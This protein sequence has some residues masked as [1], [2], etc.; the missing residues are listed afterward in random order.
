MPIAPSVNFRTINNPADPT[1]NNLQ[2]INNRGVIDG[3]YG[4]GDPGHPNEGY[5]TTTHGRVFTP[6]EFPN[7]GQT[8]ANGL[9]DYGVVVGYFY[10]TNNGVP[11]DNQYGFYEM[12]GQFKAVNDPNTPTHPNPG[13]LIENQ[14]LGVNNGDIAVGFYNDAAGNSHGYTYNIHTG[15]FSADINVPGAVSTVTAAINNGGR[16]A[17]FF[18]DAAGTTHGFLDRYGHFTTVDAPGASETE[19]LGIN[20][21]N[22]AVGMDVVGGVTHGIIYNSATGAFTQLDDPN[23]AGFTLFNGINN[24]GDIVGFYT[25]AAGN[26]DGML[27]TPA[28][29]SSL[30]LV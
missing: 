2:G 25:D 13:V 26:T 23:A 9:N 27:V 3:F 21:H 4:S 29:H 14:V 20:D 28:D 17:G 12:N 8:Q 6:M 11:F 24:R 10:P 5:L 30:F 18:T 7:A 1:F 22:V 19:L 16:I 15:A